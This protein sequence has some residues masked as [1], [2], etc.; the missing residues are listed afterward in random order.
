MIFETMVAAILQTGD[1]MI[2]RLIQEKT[3]IWQGRSTDPCDKLNYRGKVIALI[4]PR[5]FSAAEA[6]LLI[7]MIQA[8]L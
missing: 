2:R 5:T 6:L 4:G 3:D 7:C 1:Q 8:G